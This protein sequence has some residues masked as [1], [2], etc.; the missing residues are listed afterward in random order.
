MASRL[1][2]ARVDPSGY[3]A[4]SD[5]GAP[6]V[7]LH[8]RLQ[9]V[10]RRHLPAVNA[11]LLAEPS[12]TADGRYVEWY[13]DLS[14]QPRKLTTLPEAEQANVRAVLG[15]RLNAL[16]GFTER[17]PDLDPGASGLAESLRWALSYPGD[18]TVYVVGD[19]P[20]ITFWGHESASGTA[21]SGP[22]VL[23][24]VEN[25]IDTIPPVGATTAEQRFPWSLWPF[26][27]LL[28]LGLLAVVAWWY[29]V[30]FR[31]PPWGD[32]KALIAAA[33]EDERA[34]RDRLKILQA[35]VDEKL[36][37]C[38]L[39]DRMEALEARIGEEFKSCSLRAAL[40][41]ARAEEESLRSQ[42][43]QATKKLADL[44]NECWCNKLPSL[45]ERARNLGSL[46]FLDGRWQSITPMVA[47]LTGQDLEMML[48][49]QHGSGRVVLYV[50]E[51]HGSKQACRGRAR[52]SMRS[53]D[54]V[55]RLS[56][57]RC[58][59]GSWFVRQTMVCSLTP[60]RTMP[61]CIHSGPNAF[62]AELAKG[63]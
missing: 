29:S 8:R 37:S 56:G 52:A 50:E 3:V 11:S 20:V 33:E 31:W 45:P 15:D 48:D 53:D 62:G 58:P 41:Q 35:V 22:P 51:S 13:S 32:D 16:Q 49:L 46:A 40:D 9:T 44:R 57:S 7:D 25:A 17:L 1:R 63:K 4:L 23:A 42:V 30:D 26:G 60:Q 34:L 12:P 28:A 2:I 38:R 10:I 36:E 18:D 43:Q 5:E 27:L 54:F 21:P 19:Q 47:T 6:T 14:G 24:P 59:D 39:R 61:C 55:I